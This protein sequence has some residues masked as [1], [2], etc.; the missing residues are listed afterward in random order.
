MADGSEFRTAP[1]NIEAEQALLGA[2]LINNDCH[3]RV[4]GFLRAAHFFD[5]VHGAIFS[6]AG[7]LIAGGRP[8]TPVTLRPFFED[9]AK[10]GEITVPQYLGKL[11][12]NATS[13]A[14]VPD[15]GRQIR[16]GAIRRALIILGGDISNKAYEPEAEPTAQI[17]DAEEKLY[18]LRA[19]A[20]ND[21]ET[22]TQAEAISQAIEAL[23]AAY[24][25][26]DGLMGLSTGLKGLDLAS[27]GLAGGHLIIIGGR[28]G[29]GK[30]ALA[31][32]MASAIAARG[33]PVGFFS[34]EMG[35]KEIAT[36]TISGQSGIP[37]QQIIRGAI[38]EAEFRNIVTGA[39]G[40]T[41]PI[42]YDETSA[43]RIG[44]LVGKARRLKSRE[45]IQALFIDYLQL[46]KG[47]SDKAYN[48]DVR[49]ITEISGALKGLARL[50]EIP[51]IALAQLNRA[52]ESRP[53]KRPQLSDLRSS[54]S[55]EQDA[56]QVWF[57]HRDSY[58]LERAQPD[59]SDGA[60]TIEWNAKMRD[61]RGKADVIIAKNRHGPTGL[62]KLQ[63]HA[64]TTSFRD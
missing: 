44:Q 30:T 38:S 27:G 58:Y 31:E 3:S 12:A 41:G 4:E 46:A 55:I 28:P 49:E 9:A 20:D 53:D 47:N 29:Q 7:K 11:A 23:S 5:P 25:R 57:V 15:Y 35:A 61:A 62:V 36:R 8:A 59:P 33:V 24:K 16:D 63:F 52:N 64:E 19:R 22:I 13:I 17:E 18:R 34:M 37:V 26:G 50:L 39:K 60:A 14:N 21:R 32:V 48:S 2:I 6:A 43:M 45:K 10:V 56:D 42:F 51:V 1:H 40:I 54:G